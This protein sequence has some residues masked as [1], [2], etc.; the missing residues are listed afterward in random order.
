MAKRTPWWKADYDAGFERAKEALRLDWEQQNRGP[1]RDN[2]EPSSHGLAQRP[3]APGKKSHPEASDEAFRFGYGA[4]QHF[5][6]RAWND[7]LEQDLRRD[8][9]GDFSGDRDC[10][11]FAYQNATVAGPSR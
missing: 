6:E 2:G 11:R 1:R 8:Y 4:R 7:R 5:T 9:S 10:I 3:P